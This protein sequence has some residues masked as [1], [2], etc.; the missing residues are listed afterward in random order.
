MALSTTEQVA[1]LRGALTR[2][3]DGRRDQARANRRRRDASAT[4]AVIR[5][6]DGDPVSATAT[7]IDIASRRSIP[8]PRQSSRR[9]FSIVRAA[10][11]RPLGLSLN[12]ASSPAK[13]RDID[14]LIASSR[15]HSHGA[16]PAITRSSEVEFHEMGFQD[17]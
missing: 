12:Q 5:E 10:H 11:I 1:P 13:N 3:V 8:L 14:R 16:D 9:C 2:I 17:N 7:M 6:L 15:V 4:E